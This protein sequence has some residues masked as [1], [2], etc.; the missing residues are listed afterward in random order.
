MQ[1]TVRI[2]M[3]NQE[4]VLFQGVNETALV[5]QYSVIKSRVIDMIIDDNT[6]Y[7]ATDFGKAITN[8]LKNAD[9]AR[10]E[11]IAPLEE[12]ITE[13]EKPYRNLIGECKKLKVM[14]DGKIS[15]YL[16]EQRKRQEAQLL[17]EKEKQLA[18]LREKQA[19]LALQGKQENVE[20]LQVA[21][22]YVEEQA[23]VTK[24]SVQGFTGAS[25]SSWK[26]WKH[27]IVNSFIVPRELCIPSDSLILAVKNKAIK[28]GTIGS[29]KIDGIEFYEEYGISYR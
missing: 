15:P 23:I 25:V 11:A 1:K 22:G 13:I 3:D 17:A 21:V 20:A 4:L 28:D 18:A 16:A 9:K 26:V 14:I 24:S 19:R 12:A 10:K 5:E 27:R 29:L 2:V 7:E 8:L 6:I